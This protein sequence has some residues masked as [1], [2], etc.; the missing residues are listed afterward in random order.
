MKG[1]KTPSRVQ[2]N[3]PSFP[4]SF[5]LCTDIWKYTIT[6]HL[7]TTWQLHGPDREQ[8]K[9]E[10]D[11]NKSLRTRLVTFPLHAV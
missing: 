2:G 3:V 11:S 10:V 6:L 7:F 9:D 1:E 5:K 8:P 4:T